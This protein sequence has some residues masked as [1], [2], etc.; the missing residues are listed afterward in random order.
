MFR[1][2]WLAKNELSEIYNVIATPNFS[3][4][5]NFVD[6]QACFS[7]ARYKY[8]SGNEFITIQK[9]SEYNGW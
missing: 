3:T 1:E 2:K 5:V 9:R 4:L 7:F 6:S 8:L